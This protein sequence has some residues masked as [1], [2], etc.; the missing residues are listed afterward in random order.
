ML[1]VGSSKRRN[2]D[3]SM[4]Q[5]ME[6]MLS[7]KRGVYSICTAAGVNRIYVLLNTF[8]THVYCVCAA[9]CSIWS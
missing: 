7:N 6:E 5:K 9:V 8:F 2:T 4:V 1:G 3:Y